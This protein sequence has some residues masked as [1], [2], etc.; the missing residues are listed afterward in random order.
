MA[1]LTQSEL[2]I[3]SGFSSRAC[4]YWESRGDNPPTSVPST[5]QVIEAVLLRYGVEVFT[6]PTPGCR[7]ISTK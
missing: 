5:L 3:E 6:A 7:F 1:G 4:R 2:S